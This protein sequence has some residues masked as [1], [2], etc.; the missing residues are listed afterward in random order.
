MTDCKTGI[1]QLLTNVIH[2]YFTDLSEYIYSQ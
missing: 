2:H 1:W